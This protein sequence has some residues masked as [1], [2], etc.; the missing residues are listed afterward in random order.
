MNKICIDERYFPNEELS[1]SN[2]PYKD[3]LSCLDELFVSYDSLF[4]AGCRDGKLLEEI[5]IKHSNVLIN[6]CDYFQFAI[7]ACPLSI[8]NDVFIWDLRDPFIEYKKYD[9][10]VSTEVAEHIDKD[11]CDVYLSNL[12][13][14]LNKY[15][16]ITWSNSGGENNREVDQHVQHLNP[17]SKEQYHEV[18]KKNGFKFEEEKTNNLIK[19]MQNKSHVHWYWTSTIGVFSIEE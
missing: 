18:M 11:Y 16:I 10:V 19:L 4:D 17:L 5:K 15:L 7:D 1:H 12:K 3:F 13:K 8:K 6:G 14:L 2:L 9:L